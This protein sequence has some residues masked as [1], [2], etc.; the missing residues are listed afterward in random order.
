MHSYLEQNRSAAIWPFW[1]AIVLSIVVHGA[2][3]Q[4]NPQL[5]WGE[6]REL[7]AQEQERI[8]FQLQDVDL[9]PP[10][11]DLPSL[12]DRWIEEIPP[13]DLLENSE[14][15]VE[16]A[17][18]EVE[19]LPADVGKVELSSI[20]PAD[21]EDAIP[22]AE[23]VFEPPVEILAIE[24]NLIVEQVEILPRAL[25][26]KVIR[27]PDGE[28]SIVGEAPRISLKVET[29]PGP[30]EAVGA[31]QVAHVQATENMDF[32]SPPELAFEPPEDLLP[33]TEEPI[34]EITDMEAV[35]DLL[36]IRVERSIYPADPTYQYF[37]ILITRK[38]IE[39]LPVLPREVILL[40]DG[41]RSMTDEKL[42]QCVG[43]GMALIGQ[44]TEKDVFNIITFRDEV[45]QCFS[46][47]KK[48]TYSRKAAANAYLQQLRAYGKTDV[49]ASLEALRKVAPGDTET[50]R[51]VIAILVT[52]GRPTMGVTR[53]SDII[54][55]FTQKNKLTASMFGVGGGTKVNRFLL[56][57]L[58]YRNRGDSSVVVREEDIPR[59][60]ARLGIQLSRP[61]LANL[62]A[63]VTQNDKV[64]L[65]PD[66]LTH[67]YLDRP[68]QLLGRAPRRMR[69]FAFQVEG[70]SATGRH[71]MVFKID[72]DEA[73][74]GDP[75]LRR[76]WAWQRIL[77]VMSRYI[78]NRSQADRQELQQLSRD[79]GIQIPY[80]LD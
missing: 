27:A 78:G 42:K 13:V 10:D 25:T 22:D 33:F 1:L 31:D 7:T 17:D 64:T 40:Q 21:L 55:T 74:A 8:S 19:L 6:G 12:L 45:D 76:Q 14:P 63:R 2:F 60:M 58:S 34:Q 35:E 26:P 72:L 5:N 51:P 77:H 54:E 53:S 9:D 20:N 57:F 29:A 43:G 41:S 18:A 48:A 67:L 36:S 24:E 80:K 79:Y 30:L 16:L 56:D 50:V 61:V 32:L 44:L 52:D 46:S 65:V 15:K 62:E 69:P 28:G 73:D 71:D 38:G 75:A 59:A 47:S 70:E 68:L 49:F 3:V 66:T 11:E 39:K 37:R 23:D 4:L